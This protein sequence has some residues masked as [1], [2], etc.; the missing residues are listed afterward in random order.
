M[1]ARF[2]LL[3]A[4]GESP[5]VVTETLWAL[6]RDGRVPGRVEIVCTATGEAHV[7]ARL[8]G[9]RG[10]FDAAGRSLDDRAEDRWTPFCQDVLGLDALLPIGFC[11]AELG[12]VRLRD[13]ETP[14][15]DRAFADVAYR[16]VAERSAPGEPPLVGSLAGG[17][18][19]MSAHLMTAFSVYARP[20]DRLTHV[21]VF[22]TR[23]ERDPSFF[24]P[25]DA[26]LGEVRVHLIDVPFPRLRLALDRGLGEGVPRGDLR[27]LLDALDP[28]ALAARPVERLVLHAGQTNTL[29]AEDPSGPV[30]TPLR[31]ADAE[32]ATLLALAEG[33]ARFGGAV[34]VAS[35]VDGG[36]LD[37]VRRYVYARLAAQP[38]APWPDAATVSKRVN[39]LVRALRAVPVFAAHV[40]IPRRSRGDAGFAVAMP[41]LVVTSDRRHAGWSEVFAHVPPPER[42]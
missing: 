28:L 38:A 27:G 3:A 32:A 17:R 10:H 37:A 15:H 31:L 41:P 35:L 4:V 14:A 21:L 40:Q 7:R 39:D 30:G 8:L 11:V 6:R 1:T 20:E 12:G 34:P 22:P 29:R 2:A 9:E 5:Q 19:T 36:A 24:H 13:V 18:K 16:A 25:T 33:V 26:L 23:F 42:A